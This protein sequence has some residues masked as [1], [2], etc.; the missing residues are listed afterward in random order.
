M[1]DPKNTAT[2]RL[3]ALVGMVLLA[4]SVTPAPRWAAS[5]EIASFRLSLSGEGATVRLRTGVFDSGQSGFALLLGI[6]R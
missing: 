1:N 2:M 6:D 3:L 4:W 5:I